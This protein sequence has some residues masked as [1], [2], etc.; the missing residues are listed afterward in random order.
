MHNL[1]KKLAV[2]SVFVDCKSSLRNMV[3]KYLSHKSD[4]EDVLQETFI[5]T[6]AADQKDTIEYPKLYMFK[7]AKNLVQREN[8]KLTAK[9]TD[10]LDDDAIQSISSQDIHP[11]ETIS[12]E[13]QSELLLEAL[14]SLPEQC[15]KVTRL[16]ILQDLSI[17]EIAN[18][19]GLSVST[20]EKHLSKGYE[21]CDNY[22]RQAAE[23]ASTAAPE[24]VRAM[25][26]KSSVE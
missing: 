25:G 12:A 20:T 22:V 15:Q 8:T 23:N 3:S 13:R 7:T 5:R 14:D 17:K 21:R 6:F 4:V 24:T 11:V 2:F 18:Q 10:Y 1:D 19:L 9:L 26:L 16:R